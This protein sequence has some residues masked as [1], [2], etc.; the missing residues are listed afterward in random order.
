MKYP[1][2][3]TVMMDYIHGWMNGMSN[4][5]GTQIWTVVGVLVVIVMAIYIFRSI[6]K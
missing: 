2:K 1:G 6:Q 5:A 3:G 4:N